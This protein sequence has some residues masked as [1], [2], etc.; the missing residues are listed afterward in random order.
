MTAIFFSVLFAH[1]GAADARAVS[2]TERPAESTA[3][4]LKVADE[5]AAAVRAR[6][7]DALLRFLP[8]GVLCIDSPVSRQE[9]EK[10][11]R[12]EDSWLAAYFFRPDTFRKRFA[13]LLVPMS[14][15]EFLDTA[16]DLRVTTPGK[17]DKHFPCVLFSAANIKPG[18][19]FCLQQYGRRWV[20][21]DLPG[22]G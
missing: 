3:S 1:A 19:S 4:V 13:D 15:A 20:F 8:P 14:F 17:Q 9:I 21:R 10:E 2:E 18:H 6:D 16:R 7:I 11:L 5:L 22:C 12:R